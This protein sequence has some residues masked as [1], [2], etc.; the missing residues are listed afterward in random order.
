MIIFRIFQF[1]KKFVSP[2]LG[3]WQQWHGGLELFI[4]FLLTYAY[5]DWE[6]YVLFGE[7]LHLERYFH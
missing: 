4:F 5:T 7:I 6:N 3:M 2:I 1:L